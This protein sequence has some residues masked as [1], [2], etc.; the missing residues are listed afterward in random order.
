MEKTNV[1]VL[2]SMNF[3]AFGII[4]GIVNFYKPQYVD[5]AGIFN[6]ILSLQLTIIPYI[7]SVMAYLI[8]LIVIIFS[9]LMIAKG[10]ILEFLSTYSNWCYEKYSLKYSEYLE[11]LDTAHVAGILIYG[12]LVLPVLTVILFPKFLAAVLLIVVLTALFK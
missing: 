11:N 5:L 12:F 4:L 9:A 8:T 2:V 10:L 6:G 7:I 1:K 3:I